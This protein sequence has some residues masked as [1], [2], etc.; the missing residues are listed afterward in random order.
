MTRSTSVW[1]D[2]T[3]GELKLSQGN[4]PALS[5]RDRAREFLRFA[6]IDITAKKK[7][8]DAF[9]S[10]PDPQTVLEEIRADK[11]DPRVIEVLAEIF[12]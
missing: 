4:A 5:N 11:Q 8:M 10:A 12:S 7:M 3:K 6:Q 1:V 2:G 9:D